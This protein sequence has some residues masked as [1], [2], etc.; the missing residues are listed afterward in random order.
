MREC[1]TAHKTVN[2]AYGLHMQTGKLKWAVLQILTLK[3]YYITK[4]YAQPQI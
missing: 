2:G 3:D 4:Y 1:R